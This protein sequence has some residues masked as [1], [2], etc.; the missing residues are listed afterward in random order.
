[1][2]REVVAEVALLFAVSPLTRSGRAVS[3]NKVFFSQTISLAEF[4]CMLVDDLHRVVRNE[5]ETQRLLG[6]R[7]A[8]TLRYVYPQQ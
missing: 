3:A 4:R 7:L 2:S 5:G 8:G 6:W 1:M